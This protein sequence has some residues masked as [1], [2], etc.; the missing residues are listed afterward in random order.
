MTRHLSAVFCLA[1]LCMGAHAA[2]PVKHPAPSVETYVSLAKLPDWSGSWALPDK[3]FTAAM[4]P[5]GLASG[6]RYQ[7]EYLQ[8]LGPRGKANAEMC[9]P[10]G[11]PGIMALPIG[12]EFLFTPGRVTIVVEEGPLVRRVFTDGRPHSEDP[13]ITYAGES[14]GHW[15]GQVLVVDTVA[16][17]PRAQFFMGPRTSGKTHVVER[18]SLQDRDH[19]RVETLVED[20]EALAAPWRYTLTYLRSN[21]PFTESYN[22]D[23]DRDSKGEP[24]L[25]P[26]VLPPR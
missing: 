11:M 16:I 4:G 6:A 19:L 3:A 9:L 13:D 21:V 17:S 5:G 7:P 15:E 8:G 23:N 12:Y 2:E 1:V 20:P 14:I 25:S 26:P 18:I 24:D 22:C 10:T